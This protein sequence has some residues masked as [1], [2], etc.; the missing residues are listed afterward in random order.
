MNAYPIQ[1]TLIDSNRTPG[2]AVELGVLSTDF[3]GGPPQ[4]LNICDVSWVRSYSGPEAAVSR[5]TCPGSSIRYQSTTPI[6]PGFLRYLDYVLTYPYAAR[7]LAVQPTV[8][9]V[10]RG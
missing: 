5:D 4:R 6:T 8:E 10:P 1:V 9:A 3:P 2:G 7:R